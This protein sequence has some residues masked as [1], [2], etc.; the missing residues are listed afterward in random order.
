[1]IWQVMGGLI[2]GLATA[3]VSEAVLRI[4]PAYVEQNLFRALAVGATL[5]AFWILGL[6]AWALTAGGGEPRVF[7]PTLLLGYLASQA[8]EG[9]RYTRFLERC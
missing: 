2:C 7:V 4:L 6:M 1:M 9:V 5:R 3:G 8:F